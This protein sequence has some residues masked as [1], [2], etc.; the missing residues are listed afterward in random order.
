LPWN[1]GQVQSFNQSKP[2]STNRRPS[3]I[4]TWQS[5]PQKKTT[6]ALSRV[7][8]VLGGDPKTEELFRDHYVRGS[9]ALHSLLF[10]C[11]TEI[12]AYHIRDYRFRRVIPLQKRTGKTLRKERWLRNEA[13]HTS[14]RYEPCGLR[15]AF[16][17]MF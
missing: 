16:Q 4:C 2:L 8:R 6:Q 13:K 3:R 9:S 12:A 10:G 7:S 15:N 17:N 5:T 1:K 14:S 11:R